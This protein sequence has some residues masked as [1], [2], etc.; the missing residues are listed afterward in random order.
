MGGD[1]ALAALGAAKSLVSAKALAC[2]NSKEP[3][4]TSSELKKSFKNARRQY[5]FRPN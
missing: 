2:P 1:A 3:I 5:C 4:H